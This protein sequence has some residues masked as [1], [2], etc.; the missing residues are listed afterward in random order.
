MIKK[1]TNQWVCDRFFF[2]QSRYIGRYL[3]RYYLHPKKNLRSKNKNQNQK[4]TNFSIIKRANKL[5][6]KV[7]T[8]N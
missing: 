6:R 2:N 3:E 7:F 5:P 4:E 1:V 8:K